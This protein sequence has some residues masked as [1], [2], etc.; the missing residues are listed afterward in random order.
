MKVCTFG[1]HIAF[2]L[3]TLFSSVRPGT[4]QPRW[5]DH[6]ENNQIDPPS[7]ARSSGSS[8]EGID[9]NPSDYLTEL[10]EF[11][12]WLVHQV[13]AAHAKGESTL[14]GLK[15]LRSRLKDLE[16]ENFELSTRLTQIM[17]VCAPV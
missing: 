3:I 15:Q 13:R 6:P 12:T 10:S 5:E 8:V 17:S 1:R 11:E 9:T 14:D 4:A 7:P 2:G 16:D